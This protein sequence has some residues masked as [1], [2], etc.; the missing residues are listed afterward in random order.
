MLGFLRLVRIQNLIILAFTLIAVRYGIL[1]TLWE[2]GIGILLEQGYWP[3]DMKLHMELLPFLLLVA[4]VI[5]IAAGGYVI[6]DYFDTK[7]DRINKPEKVFVGR[8]IS[9]RRAI[10]LHI[11]LSTL[12]IIL[13]L[14]PAWQY[15]NLKLMIIPVLSSLLLWAYSAKF[16]KMPLSGNLIIALLAGLSP[17]LVASYEFAAGVNLSLQI[18][19]VNLPGSGSRLL[20]M[21]MLIISLYAL[22]SFLITLIREIIKDIEDIDG[23]E[24]D[25]GQTLPIVMGENLAKF[26]ALG[27]IICCIVITGVIMRYLW[28]QEMNALFWYVTAGLMIPW[29][30]L[31]IML[32]N[33]QDKKAYGRAS[34]VCKL[35]MVSGL[36]SMFVFKWSF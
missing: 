33:A 20:F 35:I 28:Q 16:K 10:L 15:H 22:F 21:G 2:H 1:E 5:L 11:A 27:L 9:R 3:H 29:F 23:D 12:G 24:A 32:W 4:S 19:N 31:G 6:N 8:I 18:M 30:I 7:T 26:A 17:I 13:A 36:L 14:I 25:G 34:L